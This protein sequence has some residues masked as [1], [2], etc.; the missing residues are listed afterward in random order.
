M[1]RYLLALSFALCPVNAQASRSHHDPMSG[2]SSRSASLRAPSTRFRP[3]YS[4]T[5]RRC[6]TDLCFARN[7]TGTYSSAN[8]GRGRLGP[9]E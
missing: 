1:P 5:T 2:G 8:T 6:A 4:T 3:L 7:P 9:P